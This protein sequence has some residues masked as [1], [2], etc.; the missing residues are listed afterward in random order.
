MQA[1]DGRPCLIVVVAVGY[2][3]PD[4]CVD[5]TTIPN[6]TGGRHP[7]RDKMNNVVHDGGNEI[8]LTFALLNFW[9]LKIVAW[10]LDT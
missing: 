8:A 3:I 5:W 4:I 10:L 2:E 9:G 7:F 6:N 1:N